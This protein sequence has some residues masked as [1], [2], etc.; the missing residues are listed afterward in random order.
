MKLVKFVVVA[1]LVSGVA[2]AQKK[3]GLLEE[4]SGQGYGSAGCGLGSLVMGSNGNQI[5]AA[6]TNGTSGNQTFGISTG[7]L[8]CQ[9]DGIFKS[10]KEVP[11]FIEVNKVALANDA[12][13]GE[14]ET[15]AGLANLMGCDSKVMGT[16]LKKNYNKIFVETNMQP[17]SIEANINAVVSQN[18]VCGA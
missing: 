13:R 11:A 8:N 6:T 7:T 14:G 1:M 16:T 9:Q 18:N 15:L 10:G 3:K 4:V 17:A 12:A 5:L 2:H